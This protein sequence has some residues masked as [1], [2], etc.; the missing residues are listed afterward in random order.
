MYSELLFNRTIGAS[1][2]YF[3]VAVFTDNPKWRDFLYTA[4]RIFECLIN[5]LSSAKSSII[6]NRQNNFF[7]PCFFWYSIT[8]LCCVSI[9]FSRLGASYSSNKKTVLFCYLLLNLFLCIQSPL[10]KLHLCEQLVRQ[11]L[12]SQSIHDIITFN[13]RFWIKLPLPPW[14]TDT[15]ILRHSSLSAIS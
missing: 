8:T 9:I 13:T 14:L 6:N 15:T 10:Y 5:V 2:L 3:C 11:Y 7:I 12:F 1:A 4:C